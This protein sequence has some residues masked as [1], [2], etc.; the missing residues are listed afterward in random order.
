MKKMIF[1]GMLFIAGFIGILSLGIVSV[2]NPV[3]YNGI[4]GF[5]GFLLDSDMV[6][7]F[8]GSCVLCAAGFIIC[9][10]DSFIK[11]KH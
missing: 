3:I 11:R 5:Q 1:G 8:V 9:L 2:Y 4:T 10:V 6:F 7:L